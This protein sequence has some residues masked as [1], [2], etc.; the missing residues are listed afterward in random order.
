[1]SGDES[2]ASFNE[3]QISADFGGNMADDYTFDKDEF[4]ELEKLEMSEA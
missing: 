4:D 1:M 2:F 3:D